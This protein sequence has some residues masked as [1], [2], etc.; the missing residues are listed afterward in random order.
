[1]NAIMA[2]PPPIVKAPTLRK[3]A[4]ICPRSGALVLPPAAAGLAS[5]V[6]H[7]H[8]RVNTARP[9]IDDALK[10]SA[11]ALAPW[12]TSRPAIPARI[13]IGT[14]P[15]GV[16]TDAAAAITPITVSAT[17]VAAARPSRYTAIA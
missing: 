8:G 6:G 12:N 10:A 1:M 15:S 16:P 3:N 17:V 9:R 11:P 13:R 2:R 4:Q 7:H 14:M 5:P